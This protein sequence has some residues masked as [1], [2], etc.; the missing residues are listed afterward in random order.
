M[1][2]LTVARRLTATLAAVTG[3]LAGGCAPEALAPSAIPVRASAGAS[4]SVGPEA[5]A[6]PSPSGAPSA[7]DPGIGDT[8]RLNQTATAPP[9]QS[10]APAL[11]A[12]GDE[13]DQVRDLQHRL[14]QLEWLEW[15]ITGTYD[16]TTRLAVEG[17]QA[18]RGIPVTGEVDRVT[19]DRLAAMTRQPTRDEMYNI[20]RPGP[21]LFAEGDEGDR[22][23]DIQARLKQIGWYAK[24][25]DGIYGAKTVRAVEGFQAKRRIPVTGEV[26]QRTLD[27]LYAMT[28]K[29]T[30]DE[31]NN[32]VT[33]PRPTTMTLDDR[34]LTGRVICISK[35][36][37]RLAWVVDGTIQMTMDVRFGSELTPTRNGVFSVYWKSRDHVSRLYDTPM[38]YALFFSG[39]QAVHYSADF[40][41]N[42]YNGASHGCV[43]VRNKTAVANLFDASHVG[44]KVVVYS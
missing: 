22:V 37:R 25:I 38:P 32:V 15:P 40:A 33:A 30:T 3:L 29:P 17:F 13:G 39:G 44:D 43:N 41:R 10:T 19:L 16:D 5:T 4:R 28:R 31:L 2:S 27:R 23:K 34:C 11:L 26:D 6:E 9:S 8:D 7:P 14:L 42:G 20:L 12:P 18:K 24:K 36:Q 21:A 35:T 1:I